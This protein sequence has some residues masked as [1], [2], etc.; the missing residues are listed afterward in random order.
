ME[1]G[2]DPIETSEE[3]SGSGSLVRRVWP[4]LVMAAGAVLLVS[5]MVAG[6]M[7]RPQ[8]QIAPHVAHANRLIGEGEHQ[9]AIDV[10]NAKVL[11]LVSKPWIEDSDR[12]AYHLAVARSV[13]LGQRALGIHHAEND[14]TIR[15]SY[16]AAEN[17]GT[18]LSADDVVYLCDTYEALGMEDLA[19]A[20][21]Q[22]LDSDA[23]S[24]R[25]TIMRRMVEHELSKAA[26]EFDRAISLLTELGS[27]HD[28]SLEDR[29]WS[30]ARE[31]EIRLGQGHAAQAVSRLL[32]G[33][34]RLEGA[35]TG[36]IA[37][38]YVLLGAAYLELEQHPN[39][40]KQ[41]DRAVAILG[42]T[43]PLRARAE[44]VLAMCDQA[45]G[46]NELARD[47]Y[48]AVVGW[49]EHMPWHLPALLGL[50]ETEGLLGNVEPSL[51]AYSRVVAAIRSG[52]SHPLVSPARVAQSLLG[53]AEDR[54]V[55]ADPESALRFVVRAEEL[56]EAG[57]VPPE[58]LRTIADAH[59]LFA[60]TLI[61][62]GSGAGEDPMR[63]VA[64][65]DP[66]TRAVVQRHYLAAAEYYGRHAHAVLLASNEGY[67][68]S[69][70]D[71]ALSFDRG[72]DYERAIGALRE[73]IE[74]VPD[75]PSVVGRDATRAEARFRLGRAYQARGDHA[76]AADAFRSLI[77]EED[78]GRVGRYAEAS[79]VPLAQSL[80]ADQIPANDAEAEQILREAV[81]G[82]VGGEGSEYFHDALLGLG[83]YL[84]REQQYPEAI[85]RLRETLSRYPDDESAPLIRYRLADSLRREAAGIAQTLSSDAMPDAQ[86]RALT[87]TR[88]SH[89]RDALTLF[90]T[91]R[92][93]LG[94]EAA[95]AMAESKR[96]ALRNAC[97]YLGDCAFD[98]GDFEAAVTHYEAA[99]ERY[100]SDP[101]SLTALVQ[102]VNSYVAM[103]EVDRA[104]AANERAKRFFASLPDDAWD[105][106][107]LPMNR[108]DW[109]RWLDSTAELYGFGGE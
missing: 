73:F 89:L 95:D 45:I 44:C 30:L 105:D 16:L 24:Q 58:V 77:D 102:V 23:S 51:S 70:W 63:R 20:R 3:S 8:P 69:L 22:R 65:L 13:Y 38:L 64:M 36:A 7:T 34:V 32:P 108:E 57:D 47:R 88:E 83:E 78:T 82:R 1:S 61:D 4:A 66:A 59:E 39:A 74:G 103:G 106:P 50:A 21:V 9:A 17:F 49:S 19:Y 76:L 55:A 91:V 60:E 97:F 52:E 28:L 90:A 25:R 15:R 10:L 84:H 48:S 43:E 100:G 53:Q 68:E 33:I 46:E 31:T 99:R 101:A 98:L 35:P 18:P 11:P 87:T 26:P 75:D 5:G 12:G 27:D 94:G 80:L 92:D 56:F 29:A 67:V 40:V 107:F 62:A 54:I 85:E 79:Y 14:E 104:K 42:E 6:I 109:E 71:S 86:A 2:T 72:G 81:S 96:V 37:E 93:E 41:L